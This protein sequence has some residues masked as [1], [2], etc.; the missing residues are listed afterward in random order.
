MHLFPIEIDDTQL[1][2]KGLRAATRFF[3][4]MAS[5][6]QSYKNVNA[7][8]TEIDSPFLNVAYFGSIDVNEMHDICQ[9][10]SEFFSHYQVPWSLVVTPLSS[11]Q[12]LPEYLQREKFGL[13]ESVPCMYCDLSTSIA[14]AAP[15]G[16]IVKELLSSDNLLDWIKPI[17]EGFEAEDGGEAFRKLN[18]KISEKEGVFKQFV[19]TMDGNVVSSGT[20]FMIE[21]V[22]MIHNIATKTAALKKGYGTFLTQHLMKVAKDL[23]YKHCYLE[24]SESGYN[25]Y[26]KCGFRVYGVNHYFIKLQ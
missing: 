6:K 3:E 26:R 2:A 9:N 19:G 25:I 24:S 12:N 14:K 17:C 22:V 21:D 20:L 11:P 13:L 23:G 8:A 10:V 7:I 16:L 18:T 5:N 15:V 4:A 1:I